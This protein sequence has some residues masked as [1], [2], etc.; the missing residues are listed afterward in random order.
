MVEMCAS[1]SG[2]KMRFGD[3]HA[4]RIGETLPEWTGRDFDACGVSEF[5]MTWCG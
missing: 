2:P 4:N 3:S 1:E 5:W